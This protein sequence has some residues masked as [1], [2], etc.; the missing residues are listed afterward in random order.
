MIICPATFR[1]RVAWR[2]INPG[3]NKMS[4]RYSSH[5][6]S[7][8]DWSK[9]THVIAEQMG[10][11]PMA[12]YYQRKRHLRRRGRTHLDWS[13]VDWSKADKHIARELR[14]TPNAVK[15]QRNK[16]MGDPKGY[17]V[18]WQRFLAWLKGITK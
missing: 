6:W 2:G 10:V 8:V 5:D 14:C 16:R 12:V 15:Y 17:P 1:W 9:P 3:Q 7:S 4:T 13:Q 11:T 18:G